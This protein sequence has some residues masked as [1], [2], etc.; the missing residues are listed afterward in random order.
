[1][2]ASS[3]SP[4]FHQRGE[5]SRVG[6]HGRS[7]TPVTEPDADKFQGAPHAETKFKRNDH[8]SKQ[9]SIRARRSAG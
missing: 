8:D 9:S 2:Q 6:P 5:G 4:A 7:T 3:R 1:M